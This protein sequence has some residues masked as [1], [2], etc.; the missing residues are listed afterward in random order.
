MNNFQAMPSMNNQ[1]E[2]MDQCLDDVLK[3]PLEGITN[4]LV[5]NYTPDQMHIMFR[6][7]RQRRTHWDLSKKDKKSLIH[8]ES[9]F[10][11]AKSAK[12]MMSGVIVKGFD[13]PKQKGVKHGG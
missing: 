11:F 9:L 2:Q 6:L 3:Q 13:K 4:Y 10:L 7:L 8:Y 1:I 12:T 5:E